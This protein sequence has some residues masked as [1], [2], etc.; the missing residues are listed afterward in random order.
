[1]FRNV[2][3]R[4]RPFPRKYPDTCLHPLLV[5]LSRP[6]FVVHLLPAASPLRFPQSIF[7]R[8]FCRPSSVD[9]FLERFL[10]AILVSGCY[11]QFFLQPFPVG[12]CPSAILPFPVAHLIGQ[13]VVNFVGHAADRFLSDI[14]WRP[15]CVIRFLQAAFFNDFLPA[16]LC[17][18]PSVGCFGSA[19]SRY[20][21]RPY[22]V[23]RPAF[24]LP[25]PPNFLGRRLR[26][27]S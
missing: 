25:R 4:R 16:T 11:Q 23:S 27:I 6:F 7:C 17:R 14:F 20:L 5:R 13:F 26:N 9:R 8:P 12:Q 10:P 18:P 2:S 19:P 24:F 21:R 22:F 3:R 1:M 15:F